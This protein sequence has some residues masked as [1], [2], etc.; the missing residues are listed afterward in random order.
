[1][2]KKLTRQ[3]MAVMTVQQQYTEELIGYKEFLKIL[4]D[5]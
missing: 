4:L 1:M 3:E 2:R 5:F